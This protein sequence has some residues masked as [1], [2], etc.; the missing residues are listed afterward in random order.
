MPLPSQKD[1]SHP[2]VEY[3]QFKFNLSTVEETKSKLGNYGVIKGYASTFD[4]I[5]LGN[6]TIVK[7][8]FVKTID[9]FRQRNKLIP[10]CFQHDMYNPIGGFNPSKM[11]E[12]SKGLWVEGEINLDTSTGKDAYALAKQGVV[13]S[14]SIGFY[15]TDYEISEQMGDGRPQINSIFRKIKE[16]ILNE[17][18]LTHIPMNPLAEINEV[19][20]LIVDLPLAE[21]GT[22]WDE[23]DAIKNIRKHTD[24]E[25]VINDEFKKCFFYFDGV[26]ANDFTSYHF[27]FVDVVKGKLRAIPHAIFNAGKSISTGNHDLNVSRDQILKTKIK[28]NK[29][30]SLLGAEVPFKGINID[31]VVAVDDLQLTS[32]SD[33]IDDKQLIEMKKSQL[34]KI[35]RE[36]GRFSRNAAKCLVSCMDFSRLNKI[37]AKQDLKSEDLTDL[38]NTFKQRDAVSSTKT[39]PVD[40]ILTSEISSLL[41]TIRSSR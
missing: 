20:N 6:D 36:T 10:M 12:D 18:T 25:N 29:Y 21:K 37:N 15:C 31:G 7:G 1:T 4:N 28:I 9:N 2:A 5:D 11:Y 3:K 13:D 33:I 19:K 14:M 8:A 38:L 40:V 23:V 34:E 39:K 22:K 35:L 16:V 32:N 24:S 30:Y 26:D 17:I 27:P 41:K